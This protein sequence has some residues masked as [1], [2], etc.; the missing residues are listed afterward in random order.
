MEKYSGIFRQWM[1]FRGRFMERRGDESRGLGGTSRTTVR[2]AMLVMLSMAA[3]C[4]DAVGFLGLGQIFV[5]NMTG[6]TVLLGLAVGQAKGQA[7]LRAVVALVGFV[8]GVGAGAAILGRDQ[9]GSGW[10]PGVTAALAVELVLLTAFAVGWFHSG[11]ELEGREVYPLILVPALAM[12]V[13]SAAVRRLGIPGV[14][15]TYITGTLTGL[16]ERAIERLRPAVAN[17]VSNDDSSGRETPSARG[18]LLP[19]DVW[20]AYG[21][22]AVIVGILAVRWP[23][24]V[25]SVPVAIVALVVATATVRFHRR[26]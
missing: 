3:G 1:S 24:G 21:I 17:A 8:A 2:N 22:G 26:R 4:V 9:E 18:L 5:A 19:A 10:S 20:L 11:A 14:A 15:T 12:G 6:N 16:A 25:L 23:S 7:A 13:Q